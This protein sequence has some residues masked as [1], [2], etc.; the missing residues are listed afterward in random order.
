MLDSQR[1][2]ER[3]IKLHWTVVEVL[4]RLLLLAFKEFYMQTRLSNIFKIT[5][6]MNF[7]KTILKSSSR[8]L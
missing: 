8:V 5:N 1:T 6:V 2:F 3:K 7:S 4:L